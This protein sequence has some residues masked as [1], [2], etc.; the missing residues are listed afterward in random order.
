M[1]LREIVATDIPWIE[2]TVS[3]YFGGPTV[4]SRGKLYFIRDLPGFLACEGSGPVGLIQYNLGGRECEIVV[5]ISTIQHMGI[6]RALIDRAIQIA[7]DH[8]CQR[9]WLITTNDNEAALKFYRSLGWKQVAIH[10]GAMRES[11]RLKPEIPEFNRAG[12]PIEDELE[13][14]LMLEDR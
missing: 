14:E 7:T 11:R 9:L 5:L 2:A 10:E 3:K 1:E 8:A 4:V 12:T 6:G 13:F